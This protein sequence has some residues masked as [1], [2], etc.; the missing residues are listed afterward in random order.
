MTAPDD[1][2]LFQA[3]VRSGN[4][5]AW[6]QLYQRCTPSLYRLALYLTGAPQDAEDAVHETWLRGVRAGEKFEGRSRLTTWLTGILLNCI[7]EQRRRRKVE[8]L[9]LDDEAPL[10]DPAAPLHAERVDLERALAGLPNGYRTVLLLHDLEGYTHDDIAGMLGIDA[11][12]SKSQLSRARRA[13]VRALGT[14]EGDRAP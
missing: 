1:A 7:R 10:A 13:M 4:A 8:E 6:R 3:A 2:T 5:A 9:S 11:G 14:P 12:T